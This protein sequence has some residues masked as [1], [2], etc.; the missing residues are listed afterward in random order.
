MTHLSTT[1]RPFLTNRPDAGQA[2]AEY[3]VGTVGAVGI[4]LLLDQLAADGTLLEWL[5]MI[6]ERAFTFPWGDL[7]DGKPFTPLRIP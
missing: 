5:R 7:F 3:A 6:F 4:A 1:S 2:T